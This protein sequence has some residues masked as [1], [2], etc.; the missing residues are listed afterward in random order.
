[1]PKF[2]SALTIPEQ[3]SPGNPGS[4]FLSL[5]A[6]TGGILWTRNSAGAERL[7]E[8]GLLFAFSKSGNLSTGSG[9]HRIYNDAGA[10]LAIRAVRASVGTAPSGG[11]ILIDINV[12]GTTI[13]TTQSNRPAISSG[14]NTSGRIT[15]MNVATVSNGSYFTVDIDQVGSVAPGADLTVQIIC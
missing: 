12:N 11:S 14:Q 13:F 1:M 7:V 6:K 2:G 5:F 4:G 3:A 15:N 8:P 10:T 9:A